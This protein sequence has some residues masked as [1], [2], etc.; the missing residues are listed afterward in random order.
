MKILIFLIMYNLN[1]IQLMLQ[2]INKLNQTNKKTIYKINNI[3]LKS[4]AKFN[5]ILI[6]KINKKSKK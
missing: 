6:I 1:Q 5:Q 2:H 3:N 4:K